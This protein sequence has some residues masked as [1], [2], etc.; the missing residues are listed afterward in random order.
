MRILLINPFGIGD[1]L[2]TTPLISAIKKAWP[3]SF[4]GFWCNERVAELLKP[5][6]KIDAV[7]GLSR[8]DIKRKYGNCSFGALKSWANLYREIKKGKFDTTFDF[9][10]D[11]RY[12]LL[13]KLAGIK[14]RIGFDY[15]ARGKLLTKRIEISGYNDKH[16]V[17]YYLQLLGFLNIK[18]IEPR[19]ELFISNEPRSWAEKFVK[20]EAGGNPESFFGVCPGAGESWGKDAGFKRLEPEKFADVCN[21]IIDKFKVKVLIFGN[22]Q[23]E[24]ACNEVYANIKDKSSALKIYPDFTLSQFSALLARCKLLLTND[25]GPL[26]MAV[27][28]GVKTVSIFGPVSEI[29]YGPY[30]ASENHVVIKAEVECRPCYQNFRFSEC[31][32]DKQCL[33]TI[34]SE[35]IFSTIERLL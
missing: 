31:E 3:G 28:L 30:P 8:G 1:C 7:W 19:L 18:P 9:S 22:R 27:A 12:G 21:K 20:N 34:K 32:K 6:P 25:G 11:S 26:H 4:L 24:K 33:S 23:D 35:N 16:I 5:N 15:K 2:F 14:E 17:E 10:L 13:S 29:V